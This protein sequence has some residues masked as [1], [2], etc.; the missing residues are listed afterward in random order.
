[1]LL[2]LAAPVEGSGYNR[3]HGAFRAW[4]RRQLLILNDW[5]YQ[6]GRKAQ[7]EKRLYIEQGLGMNKGIEIVN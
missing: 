5:Q 2:A 4:L 7:G 3:T 1:M 6:Y